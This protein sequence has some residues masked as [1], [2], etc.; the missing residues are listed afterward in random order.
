MKIQ[1][2]V[3]WGNGVGN[4]EENTSGL[5]FTSWP[6]FERLKMRR[7]A[8]TLQGCFELV[9]TNFIIVIPLLIEF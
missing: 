2:F 9:F 3:V 8:R 6:T 4:F 1:Y 7:Y 5:L